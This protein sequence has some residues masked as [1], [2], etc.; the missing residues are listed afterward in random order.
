MK[1]LSISLK[2]ATW[3][4]CSMLLGLAVFGVV[5]WFVLAHSMLSWKDRTLLMRA[6]RVEAVLSATEAAGRQPLA[7][8]A[9]DA[10][11][12]ELLGILP[13]GEWI[14][15]TRN[16]GT[17][18][19]PRGP[20]PP[21]MPVL[22]FTRCPLP[23][24][25]DRLVGRDH[26]RQLCH[27]VIYAGEP[28]MLMVPSPLAEDH[29]LLRTFTL[30]LYRLVPLILVVSVMGG[31]ALSRRA[32][33]PVDL[34]IEEACSVTATDLSRRL[35]VPKADDQMRRL[36]IAWN[37]LL[38]RIEAA[39]IRVTQFTADASHELRNPIAYIRAAAEFS[40]GNAAVD[41]ESREAFRAIADEAVLTGELLEN[42]L[43]LAHPNAPLSSAELEPVN[44]SAATSEIAVHFAPFI[45]KKGQTLSLMT[46]GSN[47]LLLINPLHFRRI[48]TTILDNAIKYTPHAGHVSIWYEVTD[49]FSLRIVDNGIGIANQHLPRVF[50]RFYRV[51]PSRSE[52]SGGVGLGLPIARWLTERY[53]GQ[54]SIVSELG[55]GT[56]VTVTFPRSMVLADDLVHL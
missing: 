40:L 2:L 6:G 31:Y 35:T 38:A 13:E 26:F 9:I 45:K 48:L 23:V 51:N 8:Q 30:G 49:N 7:Q 33:R 28:A 32:L 37:D 43:T 36:A 47:L 21:G 3:Y 34:L 42:L 56:A 27:P 44:V 24:L 41:Q 39:M 53:G 50:D 15:L 14:Q 29:I 5:M 46:S 22:P 18:V 17:R 12:S 16:D 20:F 10:R 54:T 52:V 4:A 55:N 1:G 25:R 11:L 19:F